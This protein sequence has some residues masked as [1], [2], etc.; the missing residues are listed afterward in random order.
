MHK[1][2][3]TN[4]GKEGEEK[5]ILG[6]RREFDVGNNNILN[7]MG[8]KSLIVKVTFDQDIY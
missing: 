7:R 5:K 1:H 3:P 8:S 4:T 6:K 2:V